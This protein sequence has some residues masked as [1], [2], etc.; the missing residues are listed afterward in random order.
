MLGKLFD[1]VCVSA[2]VWVAVSYIQ[3]ML[4]N[5]VGFTY[6]AWNAFIVMVGGV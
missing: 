1:V 3:V 6:P 2:F 5:T 4:H